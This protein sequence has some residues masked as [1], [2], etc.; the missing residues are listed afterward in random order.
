[1][2]HTFPKEGHAA[3]GWPSRVL[4]AVGS[5][6]NP[7]VLKLPLKRL[8]PFFSLWTM[9]V[10]IYWF[11]TTPLRRT[12]TSTPW[13]LSI[14]GVMAF[15]MI[16]VA[17]WFALRPPSVPDGTSAVR[18]FDIPLT[19]L[20]GATTI[21]TAAQGLLGSE[22]S[23]WTWA[24]TIAAGLCMGWGYLRWSIPYAE[25]GIRDAT[26]CLAQGLLG[27]ETSVWT[28]A[29]TIAAGLCMGWGYL[30]WSIPYAELGIRDATA[31]LFGSYLLGP[32]VKV[33][34]DVAPDLTGA[35]AALLL[36]AVSLA[37]L[38]RI[39]RSHWVAPYEHRGSILYR[40]DT[41]SSLA[42]V[43]VCVLVF[44]IVRRLPGLIALDG[45]EGFG[46]HL[47]GHLIEVGLSVAVLIWVFKMNRSIDFAW[48]W[49]FVFLFLA[50][51]LVLS[52]VGVDAGVRTICNGVA[53]SLIVIVLWLLLSDIAH[54]SKAHPFAVF[55]FGWS[56]YVGGS[57][58][59]SI[60]GHLLL[61]GNTGTWTV[62]ACL[63]ALW[64]IGIVMVFCLG[65]ANPDV[66]RIFDDIN[67]RVPVQ[68]HTTID[69]RCNRLG[70]ER[71]LTDRETEVLKLLAKG[72]SK[73]FIA[74]EL[75]ISENTVRAH[76]RRLYAKLEVHTR[77][78][79]QDLIGL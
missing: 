37:S 39:E 45:P 73:A 67:G 36:P 51:A 11:N 69:M 50:T 14:Y 66:R 22:T 33:F 23:V 62:P 38:M 27:S 9:H 76:S 46:V 34:F 1:M 42:P 31:C 64:L 4:P 72:R 77:D 47:V 19:V 52:G 2:K 56:L 35:V 21:S 78:E 48:L 10:W 28:W 57:Y 40:K 70:A 75:Y 68:E 18:K 3:T 16:A 12:A 30:R 8:L 60:L 32:I 7:G 79:L 71:G 29:N 49:R 20:M 61:S 13:W 5:L 6:H 25:L 41:Y 54:H 74:E 43:A 63:G 24:N 58:I 44:C 65:S 59:G 15:A 53:T 17:T 55:G 26:A